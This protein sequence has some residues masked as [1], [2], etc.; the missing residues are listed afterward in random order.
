MAHRGGGQEGGGDVEGHHVV[1]GVLLLALDL[2][3]ASEV[4]DESSDWRPQKG[5]QSSNAGQ[6]AKCGGQMG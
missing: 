5:G 3:R 1:A 2:L 6:D 4:N